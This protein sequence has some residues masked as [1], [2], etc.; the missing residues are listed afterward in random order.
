MS[1]PRPKTRTKER[2]KTKIEKK[3]KKVTITKDNGEIVI[4]KAEKEGE[5]SFYYICDNNHKGEYSGSVAIADN[6]PKCRG[7]VMVFRSCPECGSPGQSEDEAGYLI[8]INNEVWPCKKCQSL[9]KIEEEV[10]QIAG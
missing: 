10:D 4:F 1:E 9:L 8:N 2:V 6:C 7:L 3:N 5:S